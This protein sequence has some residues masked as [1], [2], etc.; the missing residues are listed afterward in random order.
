VKQKTKGDQAADETQDLE[1]TPEGS[2]RNGQAEKI[3]DNSY[4]RISRL[5]AVDVF[6]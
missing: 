2:A 4:A 1:K 5:K 3:L 6:V